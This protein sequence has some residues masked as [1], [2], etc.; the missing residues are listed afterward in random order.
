MGKD[1]VEVR[2]EDLPQGYYVP[3]DIKPADIPGRVWLPA[4]NNPFK[5]Q[6]VTGYV[7]GPIADGRTKTTAGFTE[8]LQNVVMPDSGSSAAE[9]MVDANEAKRRKYL[10]KH[11]T[12][13]AKDD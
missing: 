5:P 13:I 1:N 3:G 2:G 8:K 11:G 12:L 10:E 4:K 6:V 9:D 7:L